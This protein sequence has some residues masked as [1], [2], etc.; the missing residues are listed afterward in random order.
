[1]Q[2]ALKPADRGFVEHLRAFERL[3]DVGALLGPLH[4]R[5]LALRIADA[6]RSSERVLVVE[7]QVLV[8]AAQLVVRPF[9]APVARHAGH[10]EHAADGDHVGLR[11]ARSRRFTGG[12]AETV[13]PPVGIGRTVNGK[14]VA[15]FRIDLLE[16]FMHGRTAQSGP[17]IVLV[18][19]ADQRALLHRRRR[20]VGGV[21]RVLRRDEREVV[22]AAAQ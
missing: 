13:G 4:L 20:I 8:D 1:M 21:S 2:V 22:A 15:V 5:V 14:A 9:D 7:E 18:P 10:R 6:L 19:V 17:C 16:E 12:R 3:P 11:F